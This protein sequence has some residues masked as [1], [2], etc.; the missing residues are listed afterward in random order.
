MPKW[1]DVREITRDEVKKCCGEI[2][3]LISAGFPC[4]PHSRAGK[5]R[6]SS[7]QRDMWPELRRI[8]CDVRP[9]WFLGENV[10]GILST[11]TGV[12]F[13]GILRD[14]AE[15]G[16]CVGWGSYTAAHVGALHRRERVFIVAHRTNTSGVRFLHRRS[17]EL[18]DEIR[19]QAQ[20]DVV[21]AC[22][23]SHSNSINEK[24]IITEIPDTEGWDE[25]GKQVSQSQNTRIGW[26]GAIESG[27][28]RTPDGISKGVDTVMNNFMN[29]YWTGSWESG[30]E[31][32]T[33]EISNR[34]NRLEALGNAVVP[35][36]IYPILDAIARY[37]Q[38]Q[39][40]K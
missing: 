6:G 18:T 10:P 31:R 4:Q 27:L 23:L 2:P 12:F 17:E 3:T 37:E 35:Q 15:M 13:G 16:Y 19:E 20:H 24:R 28:G 1:R 7:D 22:T 36:Q 21:E 34:R 32:T 11:D 40:I 25:P 39:E 30:I 38:K 5:R 29:N 8:I 33:Q 14:L 26:R 9:R